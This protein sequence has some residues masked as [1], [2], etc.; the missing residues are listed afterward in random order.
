MAR[1]EIIAEFVSPAFLIAPPEIRHRERISPPFLQAMQGA[2]NR[3]W[4]ESRPITIR[5]LHG[6]FVAEEGLILSAE[7]EIDVFSIG[8]HQQEA[9][10]SAVMS[11]RTS[12]QTASFMRLEGSVVLCR[13]AGTGNYG[14]W[15]VEML[16]HAYFA[17]QHLPH[18]ARYMVQAVDGNLKSIMRQTLGRIGVSDDMVLVAGKEPVFVERLI[19]VDGLTDHGVYMSPL[20]FECLDRIAQPIAPGACEKLYASRGRSL[21]RALLNEADF[22]RHAAAA[23]FVAMKP[24]DMPFDRQ[25]AAFKAARTVAG[26]VGAN[27]ANLVFCRPGTEVYILSPADMPD[28]FF[29]FICGLRDLRLLD[30]RCRQPQAF[31]RLAW[32]S[33]LLLDT[34]D[35]RMI[36]ASSGPSPGCAS[37]FD[38]AYYLRQ[39]PPDLPAGGDPLDHYCRT[40]WRSGLDPSAVFSTAGYLAAYRDVADEGINPLIHYVRNGRAEGRVA[41]AALKAR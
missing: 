6:V 34:D 12:I 40:G 1:Q 36:L 15:L 30:I 41:F 37:L 4:Y 28:T 20:V 39:C 19:V 33:P 24:G 21:T 18:A 29:W 13:R 26:V 32:Q 3:A 7:G 17:A 14:H 31:E 9:I 23:G 27:L 10:D 35:Q 5:A 11:V 38:A 2:W 16:P 25:V 22:V 8:Q